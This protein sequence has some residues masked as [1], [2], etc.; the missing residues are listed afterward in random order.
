MDVLKSVMVSDFS[1]S[2]TNLI[3]TATLGDIADRNYYIIIVPTSVDKNNRPDLTPF[4]KASETVG[5]VLKKGDI[6]I[7]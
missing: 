1:K 5:K 7:Y 4:Y 6:V 3:C 2:A